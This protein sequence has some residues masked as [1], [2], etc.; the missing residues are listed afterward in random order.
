[1]GDNNLEIFY[2]I[3]AMFMEALKNPQFS[4]YVTGTTHALLNSMLPLDGFGFNY[5]GKYIEIVI[6]SK[7]KDLPPL[8]VEGNIKVALSEFVYSCVTNQEIKSILYMINNDTFTRF[9]HLIKDKNQ[10]EIMKIVNYMYSI[11]FM[12]NVSNGH[13]FRIMM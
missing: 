6:G 7:E 9:F 3:K 4:A 5:G 1:M 10:V 2:D 13:L 11:L 12:G 8:V